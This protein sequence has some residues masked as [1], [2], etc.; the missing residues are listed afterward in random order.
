M[1]VGKKFDKTALLWT[2]QIESFSSFRALLTEDK[3][4]IVPIPDTA[5]LENYY[6]KRNEDPDNR[7]SN[8]CLFIL[9][10]I[11]HRLSPIDLERLQR[12]SLS[13]NSLFVASGDC[14]PDQG[15]NLNS[16][17]VR[18][19]VK[20]NQDD[21]IR[22]NPYKQYHPKEAQLEDFI[23]NRG[24]SN[25]LKKY[26]R[27]SFTSTSLSDDATTLRENSDIPA[28]SI[29]VTEQPR[30]LYANGCTLDVSGKISTIMMTSSKWAIPT[31][32]AICS[33][34]KNNNCHRVIA[35]GSSL[36]LSDTYIKLEDN[37]ALIRT[38][39]DFI[40]HDDFPINISDART[41]E[42][43]EIVR[44]PDVNHMIDLPILC[45]Q[46]SEPMPED[47]TSLIDRKLFNID[48]SM[49]PTIDR[50]FHELNVIH[51][52]LTLIKP[53]FELKHLNL[54]PATYGF[55]LRRR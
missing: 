40:K 13:G 37:E 36:M 23:V 31:R 22:P 29:V 25:S 49:L 45:L 26:C 16:L 47:K 50:T 27:K 30:I 54:E 41:V 18:Y 51:Q 34:Y 2:K 4:Q 1:S 3:W 6:S 52:P 15:T 44:A 21:V 19:G 48:N 14:D 7:E 17:M 9:N 43:P 20:F 10:P 5:T 35:L 53:D 8:V 42:V 11:D 28:G 33:F 38:L 32:Q 46:E 24:L 39:I 12:F 55:L